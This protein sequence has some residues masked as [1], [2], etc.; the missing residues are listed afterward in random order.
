MKTSALDI[1]DWHK[2]SV[3][4]VVNR[5]AVLMAKLR[6]LSALVVSAI[7]LWYIKP[8]VE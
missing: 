8:V 7:L 2:R 6:N 1:N 5:S 3:R 4:L